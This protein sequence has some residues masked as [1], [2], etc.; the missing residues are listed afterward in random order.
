MP[1]DLELADSMQ[2]PQ[3]LRTGTVLPTSVFRIQS[4]TSY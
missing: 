3:R 2:S 1:Y 4:S